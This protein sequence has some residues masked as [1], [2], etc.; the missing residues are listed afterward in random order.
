MSEEKEKFTK[1]TSLGSLLEMHQIHP[2]PK[3]YFSFL[4][5]VISLFVHFES[6]STWLVS[7][8]FE[9]E[10]KKTTKN[11]RG[12][13]QSHAG[14]HFLQV[15]HKQIGGDLH[16]SLLFAARLSTWGGLSVSNIIS[17]FSY[18]TLSPFF[19]FQLGLFFPLAAWQN[20]WWDSWWVIDEKI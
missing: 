12:L 19:F 11:K 9:R 10:D 3:A 7:L 15:T 4:R 18:F 17:S 14:C 20:S 8:C 16:Y 2:S 5:L 13:R 6:F 1:G